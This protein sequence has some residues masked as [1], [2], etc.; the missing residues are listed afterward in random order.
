M[1]LLKKS[2][3]SRHKKSEGSAKCEWT[4]EAELAFRKL[5]RTF[6]EAPI[7]QHFDPAKPIMLQTDTSGFAIA[8]ILTST[9]FSGFSDQSISTPG[10]APQPNRIT[11]LM[12]G[13]YWPSWK[14][15]N[16][17]GITSRVQTK[18]S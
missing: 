7:L 14:Y 4:R 12:I 3:T 5:K 1:E 10:S 9:M 18:R 13:S 11:T 17:G 2:E 15:Y 8:G 16:S 6:T